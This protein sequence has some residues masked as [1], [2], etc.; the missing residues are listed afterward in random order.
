MHYVTRM[1]VTCDSD[2]EKAVLRKGERAFKRLVE[3]A[4]G[5]YDSF[6]IFNHNEDLQSTYGTPRFGKRVNPIK[7]GTHEFLQEIETAYSLV[8][9][10]FFFDMDILRRVLLHHTN[11][12]I[13]NNLH[14]PDSWNEDSEC[15]KDRNQRFVCKICK[16]QNPANEGLGACSDFYFRAGECDLESN[17]TGNRMF[18]YLEG[19]KEIVNIYN[20]AK[21]TFYKT[22][23]E[24]YEPEKQLWIVLADVHR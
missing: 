20:N 21:L 6:V 7:D 11:D 15:N 5:S 2:D 24:K 12:T 16:L 17:W 9:E 10:D 22:C 8:K 18:G 13:Y 4:D 3:L 1:I 19:D 23:V 14:N